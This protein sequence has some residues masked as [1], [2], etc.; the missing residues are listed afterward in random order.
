MG[1]FLRN[2]ASPATET[3]GAFYRDGAEPAKLVNA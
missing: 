3:A 1:A 2:N